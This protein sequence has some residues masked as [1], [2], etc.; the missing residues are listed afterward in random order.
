MARAP[1][2]P[3][4]AQGRP[5]TDSIGSKRRDWSTLRA[6]LRNPTARQ[7]AIFAGLDPDQADALPKPAELPP[8]PPMDPELA[9]R[10][11]HALRSIGLYDVPVQPV[12]P[13]AP[14]GPAGSSAAGGKS[15]VNGFFDM[16]DSMPEHEVYQPDNNHKLA[17]LWKDRGGRG[18]PRYLRGLASRYKKI[19]RKT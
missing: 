10:A 4:G 11:T 6:A 16:L 3:R 1:K 8:L 19:P 18:D 14:P 2:R 17:E 9:R 15:V 13:V 7:V 5:Q 12:Q